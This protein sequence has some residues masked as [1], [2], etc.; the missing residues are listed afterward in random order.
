MGGQFGPPIKARKEIMITENQKRRIGMLVE[1]IRMRE[2]QGQTESHEYQTA[3]S[4]RDTLLARYGL[5]LADFKSNP[6]TLTIEKIEFFPKVKGKKNPTWL[7]SL[8]QVFACHHEVRAVVFTDRLGCAI[9]GQ[10]ENLKECV[11]TFEFVLE[12]SK[13]TFGVISKFHLN[14]I[15]EDYMFGFICG[16]LTQLQKI[17][18]EA[19]EAKAKEEAEKEAVMLMIISKAIAI[20]E[21]AEKKA[22][23]NGLIEEK[24]NPIHITDE[25]SYM[26]GYRDGWMAKK[27]LL[28]S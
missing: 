28:E 6:E 25:G 23:D 4:L 5:T 2:I 16:Y 24:E 22:K 10:P 12:R 8:F 13:H 1:Q 14:T 18:T 21:S 11:A 27:N 3:V 17:R 20:L 7:A 15:F 26:H 19:N 9:F